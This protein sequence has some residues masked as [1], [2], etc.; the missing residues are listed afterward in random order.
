MLISRSKEQNRIVSE[1]MA[2][3]SKTYE[4]RWLSGSRWAV[5]RLIDQPRCYSLLPI[6][7]FTGSVWLT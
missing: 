7:C 2:R 4:K 3:C 1:P 6:T 5:R